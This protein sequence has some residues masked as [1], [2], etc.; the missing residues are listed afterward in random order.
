[1]SKIEVRFFKN[2]TEVERVSEYPHRAAAQEVTGDGSREL[3]ELNNELSSAD[4]QMAIGIL[5]GRLS[6][7]VLRKIVDTVQERG[8]RNRK[9]VEWVVAET[10]RFDGAR[11]RLR[12][13]LP[14]AELPG[15]LVDL[16]GPDL[17]QNQELRRQLALSASPDERDT[18]HEYPSQCRGRGGMESR[19]NAIAARPWRPGKG[20][21][22]HFV[23]I[24]GFPLAFA[25][26]AG[27]PIEPDDIEVEPFRPLPALED[28]QHDV[29]RQLLEVLGAGPGQNRGI[30]TLPTGA[31]K[32]RTAVEAL[33]QWRQSVTARRG[34]LWVAQ[35]EEL[36]EQAV[37]AFREVWI[38]Q[39]HRPGAVRDTLSINRL[40]GPRRIVP[41]SPGVIVAS[42]QKLHAIVRGEDDPGEADERKKE[43][44]LMAKEI[45]AVVMD[46]A[47]RMLA[48]SYTEVLRFLDID[49][50][51]GSSSAVPMIGLTATP[52]RSVD[53]ETRK[54]TVRF[55]GRLLAP[56]CLGDDPI[57]SL[58]ERGVLARPIHR[59]ISYAGTIH[60]LDDDPR[61]REYYVRFSDF[62]PDLL[63]QLG[64]ERPRNQE[65][66][67]ILAELPADWPT[68]FFSCSVEHAKAMTVLLTR[69]G[70]TAAMVSGETRP[71]TRRFLIEEF[72][73]GRISVL[74]NYGV[75]TTGFDAPRVRALVI[76]RP[77]ASSVLYE[78]MI[79]RGMRGPRFGGTE[80]CLVIDLADNIRFGGQMAFLRYRDYWVS[81]S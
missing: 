68:L 40:W 20:W 47:H 78:Q 7:A 6:T 30:L 18:L 23:R 61:Y 42:I 29:R 53:E 63:R 5:R 37:Q 65:I 13:R 22:T 77:T 41:A 11:G 24:L 69:R 38:D 25:G 49:V 9:S 54:L 52:Y 32:T 46:E 26:M 81:D 2:G 16:M 45:G 56:N 31:G 60:S 35:S 17:L 44:A 34:I 55:H 75:L 70:R 74:C 43:L 21:P 62:H 39:G 66:L 1:M 10:E 76:A 33:I 67:R 27:D 3:R 79:G 36:C 59:I 73:A 15:F 58:R 48:P 50:A 51:R 71:A 8:R 4:R 12:P 64:Q 57:A 72:R 80:E 28:F 14:D 19:A